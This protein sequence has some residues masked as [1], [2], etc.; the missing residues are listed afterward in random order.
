MSGSVNGSNTSLEIIAF[1]LGSEQS[2][3]ETLAIREIKGWHRAHLF[4]ELEF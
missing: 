4:L 2:C 3:V 1:Y